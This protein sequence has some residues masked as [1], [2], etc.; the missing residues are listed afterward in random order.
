MSG[1]RIAAANVVEIATSYIPSPV[2]ARS[3]NPITVG[4]GIAVVHRDGMAIPA[5]WS[6]ATPY[7]A[8]EFPDATT[9]P[10]IPLDTGTTF[11]ELVRDLIALPRTDAD[12]LMSTSSNESVI[13]STN[14]PDSSASNDV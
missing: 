4:T 7:D 10:P 14:T 1:A 6:R 12:Q 3:P 2:D 9:G 8:F 5:T 13:V 11:I